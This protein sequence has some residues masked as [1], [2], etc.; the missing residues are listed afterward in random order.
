MNNFFLTSTA[1]DYIKGSSSF[2]RSLTQMT[3]SMI[4]DS[5]VSVFHNCLLQ[6]PAT[7]NLQLRGKPGDDNASYHWDGEQ[8]KEKSQILPHICLWPCNT[9]K[10]AEFDRYQ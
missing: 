9:D 7:I 1:R 4:N 5:I 6:I 3:Y 8:L 10:E 2:Y